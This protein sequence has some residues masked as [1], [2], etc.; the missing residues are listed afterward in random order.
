[1]YIEDMLCLFWRADPNM[2]RDKKLR[3]LMK[4]VKQEL[5]AVLVRNPLC[6]VSKLSSKAT[7]I[8]KMLEQ[9]AWQ[10]HREVSCVPAHIVFG[11]MQNNFGTLRAHQISDQRRVKQVTNTLGPTC[12][13][14]H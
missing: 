1:M 5:F 14:Y 13:I 8:K 6:T 11:G 10:Y 2:T 7:A 12:V 3:H 4:G 9:R